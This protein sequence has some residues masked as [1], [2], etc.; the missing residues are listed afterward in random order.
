M[1]IIS[2]D[3]LFT[4][5]VGRS[6]QQNLQQQ[7]Q[8]S[9]L[10]HV[11]SYVCL[12]LNPQ[13]I[14]NVMSMSIYIAHR[15]YTG[16]RHLGYLAIRLWTRYVYT[17]KTV[18]PILLQIWHK[19]PARHATQYAI[20][21]LFLWLHGQVC[22]LCSILQRKDT[23]NKTFTVVLRGRGRLCTWLLPSESRRAVRRTGQSRRRN[24]DWWCGLSEPVH[25]RS[26]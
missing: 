20:R 1:T 12:C 8:L 7:T 22:K 21:P 3:S 13:S 4:S 25:H 14:C 17:A 16:R 6:K 11:V 26:T 2:L 23:H 10:L 24:V 15:R 5:A 9:Y 18:E 19:W